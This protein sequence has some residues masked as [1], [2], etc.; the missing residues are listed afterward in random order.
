MG[1]REMTAEQIKKDILNKA[2]VILNEYKNK[3]IADLKPDYDP[4]EFDKWLYRNKY[5]DKVIDDDIEVIRFDYPG[6]YYKIANKY[7]AFCDFVKKLK[8]MPTHN[9][10]YDVKPAKP[11]LKPTGKDIALIE[12]EALA[13]YVNMYNQ[14]RCDLALDNANHLKDSLKEDYQATYLAMQQSEVS[15]LAHNVD[16]YYDLVGY[17]K[18]SNMELEELRDIIHQIDNRKITLKSLTGIVK[19][20]QAPSY[21]DI[22]QKHDD[23]NSRL[24]S[25]MESMDRVKMSLL[26]LYPA[27]YTD[28]FE[29][30]QAA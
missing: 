25:Y 28:M 29:T 20:G 26:K 10:P 22:Q 3:F 1:V 27:V 5:N 30:K 19:H 2:M 15:Y 4:K 7:F 16:Y 12:K 17:I 14:Y 11:S 23:V 6:G 8:S 21:K 18:E 9:K 13:E 24:C